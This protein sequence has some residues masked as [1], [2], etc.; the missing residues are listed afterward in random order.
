M[1][2]PAPRVERLHA[3][4]PVLE[5]NDGHPWENKVVFNTACIL[6]DTP[7]RIGKLAEALPVDAATKAIVQKERAVVALVYRAQGAKTAEKDHTRSTLGLALF[8]P[9]LRL[10]VRLPEPIMCPE[11]PYEDLG[12][13]DPRITRVGNQYM[14]VYTGYASGAGANRVRIILA[15]STDLV[16]WTKH[17]VLRGDF[18][19]IDNKNG[20][21]FEPMPDKPWRMLHRPMEGKDAMMVHWAESTHL[22]GE[23]KSRGVLLPWLPDP[24]F[25][26]VWTGGGA[27]PLLLA[28]GSHLVLYHIGN[29]DAK[30]KREYDL[31]IAL[32][33]LDA[34]DPVVLRA[35]PLMRPETPQETIG[36][37]DLGVNN[38][39]FIC[40]AYFWE[41]D[42][43]FP[44][45]G[46]DTR[47]LGARI[48]R[49]ELDRFLNA[50]PSLRIP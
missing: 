22:F 46:S 3:G 37:E 41:G 5:K 30:G 35:E 14:M 11:E 24:A 12:V 7:G 6:V 15:T 29:R 43:Y 8:T 4:R 18:N 47:I 21:L 10:L 40:G 19:T 42:L 16:H 13:E 34:A 44:Y 50:R 28:N 33:D 26:E 39:V 1:T 48:V 17:G 45:Q 27:P 36:D 9:D 32:V 20:M 25:K 31:G 23:W 38:V 49:G 2:V